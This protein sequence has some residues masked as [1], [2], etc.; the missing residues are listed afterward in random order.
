MDTDIDN[1]SHKELLG[2]LRINELELNEDLLYTNTKSAIDRVSASQDFNDKE[3]VCDFFRRC[4][5]R[6]AVVRGYEI[7]EM[8]RNGLAL[9]PVPRVEERIETETAVTPARI[10]EK[11]PYQGSLPTPVPNDYVFTNYTNKYAGGL[12]DPV[13][14][15]TVTTTLVLNS[16]FRDYYI[17]KYVN[18][19]SDRIRM[20][21]LCTQ[22]KP[23]Y[24]NVMN[25]LACTTSLPPTTIQYEDCYET[26]A[27]GQKGATTDF[28]VNLVDAFTNVV[29]LRL[30]GLEMLN[31]YYPV[32]EYLGTNV[33]TITS[34]DYN[35]AAN[36]P[37]PSNV[38]QTTFNIAEGSY[39]STQIITTLN[40]LFADTTL[41]W[42]V[43]TTSVVYN[44][45]T[46]KIRFEVNDLSSNVSPRRYGIDL[47][48]RYPNDIDR[49]A[50]YNLGWLL[51]F[52][53]PYYNY[54]TDYKQSFTT[55]HG[56]GINGN[57]AL[58]M[59]GTTYFLLEVDDY[60]NNHPQVLSY[61]PKTKYSYNIR[62]ILATIP[63]SAA[64]NEVLFEDSADRIHK[65]RRYF[66]PVRI[67]KLRIRLLDEYGRPVDLVNGEFAIKLEIETLNSPYKN[68]V[69]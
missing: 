60:N 40:T 33:F 48:F 68:I 13:K 9:P 67:K 21:T 19:Q 37:D 6:I 58:N 44:Q 23:I 64:T 54:F 41:P 27:F 8:M 17:P 22:Y 69:S 10:V 39:S 2:V 38:Q 29:S 49:P 24:T 55:T 26:E 12:V 15:E 18:S 47:D 56:K 32:S 46:G 52:R 31:G 45:L 7:N 43:Q 5:M 36:P 59:I 50:Y 63:N 35:P 51:G 66:G 25:T 53:K 42:G 14:R 62:D 65:C 1:Y 16:K 11:I 28:E 30:S 57:A 4:F 3:L 20:K 34:F 61:N